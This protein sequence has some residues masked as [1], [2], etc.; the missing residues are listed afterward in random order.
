MI[1]NDAI[2]SAKQKAALQNADRKGGRGGKT[3]G[4][5]EVGI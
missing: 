1:Y 5:D 2:E 4:K 3:S